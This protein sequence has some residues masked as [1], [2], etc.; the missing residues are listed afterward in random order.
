LPG[1]AV[2]FVRSSRW[3]A[4]YEPDPQCGNAQSG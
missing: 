1:R 2:H 4:R 3:L